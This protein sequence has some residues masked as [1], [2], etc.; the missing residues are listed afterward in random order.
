MWRSIYVWNC[1]I[2]RQRF[3]TWPGKQRCSIGFFAVTS[4]QS[5]RFFAGR[6][7]CLR[8]C[9][10][11]EVVEWRVPY[12]TWSTLTTHQ[13]VQPSCINRFTTDTYVWLTYVDAEA[14]ASCH[15]DGCHSDGCHSDG[16]K[17]I[18]IIIS[19]SLSLSSPQPPPCLLL[20]IIIIYYEYYYF[21]YY[22]FYY[23]Y[24]W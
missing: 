6:N 15:S 2:P 21:C 7:L 3:A 8:Y 24:F 19:S 16:F 23:Y 14:K 9:P 11:Y 4:G 10:P 13:T 5:N 17:I 1:Y 18:I 20:F 22:Y 12:M